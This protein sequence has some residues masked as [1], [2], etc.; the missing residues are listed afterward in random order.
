M[1]RAAGL[2]AAEVL[3]VSGNDPTIAAFRRWT[4]LPPMSAAEK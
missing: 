2:E 4:N 1:V 3:N